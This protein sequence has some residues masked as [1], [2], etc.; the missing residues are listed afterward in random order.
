ME[1]LF[2]TRMGNI[3]IK[4]SLA[5]FKQNLGFFW[6]GRMGQDGTDVVVEDPAAFIKGGGM[7]GKGVDFFKRVNRDWDFM[8]GTSLVDH[9]DPPPV[10]GRPAIETRRFDHVERT[11]LDVNNLVGFIDD[12][13]IVKMLGWD[14]RHRLFVD[15]V[16]FANGFSC[17]WKIAS[18]LMGIWIKKIGDRMI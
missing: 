7:R 8:L 10:I 1:L 11:L 16:S 4:W 9:S 5:I 14:E 13:V 18:L 12:G 2:K 15:V 6:I 3:K 17:H